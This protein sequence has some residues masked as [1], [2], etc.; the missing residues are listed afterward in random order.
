MVMNEHTRSLLQ[1]GD[2][3][4]TYGKRALIVPLIDTLTFVNSFPCP[5]AHDVRKEFR[6]LIGSF[7]SGSDTHLTQ[8]VH[9]WEEEAEDH[10]RLEVA[11][12]AG[13]IGPSHGSRPRYIFRY[14]TSDGKRVGF[15]DPADPVVAGDGGVVVKGE[16]T[17]AAA[18]GSAGGSAGGAG[19]E[20]YLAVLQSRPSPPAGGSSSRTP[21]F[22]AAAFPEISKQLATGASR[23]FPHLTAF[24]AQPSV[25]APAPA[26]ALV[27]SRTFDPVPAPAKAKA[28]PPVPAKAPPPV[29]AKAPA[30]APVPAK[31]PA[32][33][34]APVPAKAPAPAPAPVPAKAPAPAPAPVPAPA[35][36]PAPAPA[37]APVPAPVVSRAGKGGAG[38]GTAYAPAH[39]PVVSR[40]GK[41]LVNSSDEEETRGP[42]EE[43]GQGGPSSAVATDYRSIYVNG[44][45]I[46]ATASCELVKT[47]DI[48]TYVNGRNHNYSK[49]VATCLITCYARKLGRA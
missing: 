33:A 13:G 35:K 40:G 32:P 30:P 28:P 45:C 3:A 39:A 36:A 10:H 41:P 9:E 20:S 27:P 38:R 16:D 6:K 4:D 25:R 17:G 19:G 44:G 47:L 49:Q 5:L 8:H 34:P 11:P 24:L 31:A 1:L 43:E 42:A 29:P 18:G 21:D 23:A 7:V 46:H 2:L 14:V 26:F 37:P 48:I 15:G 22:A 12:G